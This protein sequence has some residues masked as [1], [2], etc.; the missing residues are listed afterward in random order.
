MKMTN[1][2]R[3]NTKSGFHNP[4]LTCTYHSLYLMNQTSSLRRPAVEQRPATL[5]FTNWSELIGRQKL[6]L[7]IDSCSEFHRNPLPVCRMLLS[8]A[9]IPRDIE[10]APGRKL[11]SAVFLSILYWGIRSQEVLLV[12]TYK[13]DC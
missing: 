10:H 8:K 2:T 3:R 7:T 13:T 12:A 11:L 9:P 5:N 4:V 1:E 6:C